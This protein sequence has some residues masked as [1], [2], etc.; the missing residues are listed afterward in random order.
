MITKNSFIIYYSISSAVLAVAC[1]NMAPSKKSYDT[2]PDSTIALDSCVP[3][4]GSSDSGED[5]S[6]SSTSYCDQGITLG[7]TGAVGDGIT[8]DSAAMLKAVN[9]VNAG[10][11]PGLLILG[12]NFLVRGPFQPKR[13]FI[14]G[15]GAV[16][17]LQ[18]DINAP[19]FTVLSD[20]SNPING[21]G[22]NIEISD[23]TL[24]GN[25]VGINQSGLQI[26]DVSTVGSGIAY[27]SFH[28]LTISNMGGDGISYAR[29]PVDLVFNTAGPIFSNL[30]IHD[31][32]NGFD[33]Q[34][35]G[36][37]I[38]LSNSVIQ[39]NS[40]WGLIIKAGNVIVSG[41]HVDNNH[42]GVQITNDVNNSHGSIDGSTFNHNSAMSLQ[43]TGNVGERITNSAFFQGIIQ[44]DPGA[45]G[46]E[47]ANSQIDVDDYIFG[48]NS[49]SEFSEC[50]FGNSYGNA[51]SADPTALIK[52]YHPALW[53]NGQIP[54]YMFPYVNP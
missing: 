34:T 18:T 36:E 5:A 26:G 42:N 25:N 1:S 47:I 6:S 33:I 32:L 7:Q 19:I 45:V 9:L 39:K 31:C 44:V 11:C 52:A 41:V 53:A 2:N 8:D 27:G 3:D 23:L 21:Y 20:P 24:Q 14:R 43:Y 51:I 16:S 40:N 35:R 30:I 22:N 29:N 38:E 37:Y 50:I 4:G 46:L 17:K 28:H 12:K 49:F 54:T 13:G 15:L 10:T 48:A